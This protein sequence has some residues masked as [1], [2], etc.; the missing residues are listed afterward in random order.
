MSSPLFDLTGRT[1]L[2]T[3]ASQGIGLAVATGLAAAGAAIVLNGRNADKLEPAAEGLRASGATVSTALFDVTDGA[4]VRAAID[5]LEESGTAIDILVNNAGIQRRRALEDFDH[6][7]WRDLMATNVDG[8]F[9]V[10]QAVARHMIARGR[11]KIINI[12]S[13]Q[14]ELARATIAPYAASKGAVR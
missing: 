12:G 4:A 7:D 14:S 3:G 11:G 10:G 13:V 5:G 9:Y 8:V 2:V 6:D 1:A